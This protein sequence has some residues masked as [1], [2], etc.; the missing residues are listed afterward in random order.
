LSQTHACSVLQMTSLLTNR[1]HTANCEF[2]QG[3]FPS[4]ISL[5]FLLNCFYRLGYGFVD[6]DH[7]DSASYAVNHLKSKGIQAQM[8]KVGYFCQLVSEQLITSFTGIR[9]QKRRP[10]DKV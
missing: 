6:F 1:T 4:A 7:K 2:N 9:A 3:R 10:F 8:A 5:L